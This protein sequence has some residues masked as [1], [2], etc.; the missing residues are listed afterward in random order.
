MS[1]GDPVSPELLAGTR[2]GRY[3]I[4]GPIAV[5]ATGTV[6]R[7]RDLETGA[8]VAVKW[9]ME[10]DHGGRLEIE[11]RLLSRLSHPRVVG[12]LDHL[13]DADGAV[14]IVME[15]IDGADLARVLWDRGTPA[16]P[17]A[18]AVQW[19]CEACEAIQYVNDAAGGAR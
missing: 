6:Y 16:L 13:T 18:P 2:L 10:P 8:D 11:V 15:L 19:A 12:V 7:A 4:G 3:E 17:V 1:P 5:G 14:A 9:I